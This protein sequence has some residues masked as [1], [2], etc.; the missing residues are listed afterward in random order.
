MKKLSKFD[1]L[2]VLITSYIYCQ[3]SIPFKV[4]VDG[5]FYISNAK[6]LFTDNFS[7]TY[8][9]VRE[10]GYPFFLRIIHELFGN[11]DRIV[12]GI[13]GSIMIFSFYLLLKIL[14][15][16]IKSKRTK[17]FIFTVVMICFVN[18]LNIFYS[19]MVL[20]QS[21]FTTFVNLLLYLYLKN[22]FSLISKRKIVVLIVFVIFASFTSIILTIFTFMTLL[23]FLM[24]CYLN[25]K[26]SFQIW[27][28]LAIY[29]LLMFISSSI[30]LSWSQYKKSEILN[31]NKDFDL[32]LITKTP[33][34]KP[35]D[36]FNFE[37]EFSSFVFRLKGLTH[38]GPTILESGAHE[39][40]IYVGSMM[41]SDNRCGAYDAFD[42]KPYTEMAKDYFQLSCPSFMALE[43]QKFFYSQYTTYQL[44]LAWFFYF[45]TL[46][47]TGSIILLRFRIGL[48]TSILVSGSTF[49]WL[50]LY[51]M[52]T[53]GNYDRYGMPVY[54]LMLLSN[55]H[56]MMIAVRFLIKK[57]NLVFV[58]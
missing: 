8:Y 47:I 53:N 5:Y 49:A 41:D 19:G 40:D 52:G 44:E 36:Q 34:S 3:S 30:I 9:W 57:Y 20:Q 14:I 24:V 18:P 1:N 27:R 13:Q 39:T 35:I 54:G 12:V 33:F 46:I 43:G 6:I 7:K 22:G 16:E 32:E 55:V 2:I 23:L 25:D 17:I 29:I 31:S 21:L 4:T 26:H 11:S 38:L 58:S 28:N 37:N 42:M 45:A 56:F 15:S 51:S 50:L 48:S 10:P